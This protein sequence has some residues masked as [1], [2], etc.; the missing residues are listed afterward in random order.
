LDKKLELPTV[1]IVGGETLLGRD[2]RELLES[3]S[4]PARVDLVSS[5]EDPGGGILTAKGDEPAVMIGLAGAELTN[6]SL[7]FLAASTASSVK[8]AQIAGALRPAPILIDLT[9]GLEDR[10]EARLRAP[11]AEPP[12][13]RA[14]SP[15]QLI[16]H[17]AAI[18]VAM[19]L[20]QL[21][22]VAQISR[23]VINM[24]E[25][26]SEL[27]QAGLTELQQQTVALL[28][29][30]P[31]NKDVFDAQVSFNMLPEYGEDASHS[32]AG[33]EA[34]I[35]RHLASLLSN[36]QRIPMPSLRLIHAPVFHGYSFSIWV[37]FEK[38]PGIE[39]LTAGLKSARID[40]RTKNEE[41]PSNVGAAG[42]GGIAVG[43]IA[44][45]RN[46]PRACWFWMA[47]DNFRVAAENAVEVARE[48]FA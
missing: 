21:D 33:I 41:P 30:N 2:I 34:K 3:E 17:P 7:L 12:A 8:A 29:F 31:L 6:T 37:E 47:A 40:V 23:C 36:A 35:E 45:D 26:V 48:V 11:M 18:A 39:K 19:L 1:A 27:G 38:N 42:Q 25:P 20:R 44:A 32:L 15:I 14:G 22:G 4:F 16:A 24:F 9:G 13:Y 46:H 28:S 43:G 10:P 5:I